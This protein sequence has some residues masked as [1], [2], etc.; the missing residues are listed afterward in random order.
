MNECAVVSYSAVVG[1]YV[2]YRHSTHLAKDVAHAGFGNCL[3]A[4]TQ[5]ILL[6]HQQHSMLHSCGGEPTQAHNLCVWCTIASR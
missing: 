4:A 1:T 2:Q 6:H 3:F 5:H